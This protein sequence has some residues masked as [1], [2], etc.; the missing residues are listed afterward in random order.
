MRVITGQPS[1]T[2]SSPDAP[3]FEVLEGVSVHRVSLGGLKGRERFST[4]V[5]GYLRFL[6]GARQKAYRVIQ[7]E[8]PDIVLTFHNPPLVGWIGA[9]LAR[10]YGLPFVYVLYDIHPDV[11][12]RTGWKLPTPV[13]WAWERLNRRIYE[14]AAA[15]VVLGDAMRQVLARKGVP[16]EKVFV[17]PPWARPELAPLPRDCGPVLSL[18]KALGLGERDLL[19]LYAGNMGVMHPLDPLLD[20]AAALQGEP[21]HFLFLGDGVRRAQL[22][23]RVQREGLRQV[24]FLPYQPEERFAELVAAADACFVVLEPGLEQLAVPSRAFTFLSAGRPLIA[25]MAPEAEI[26]RLV[27]KAGCGWTVST[28]E[29]LRELL[30]Q[31]IET[32][33]EVEERGRRARE[34]Y[35]AEFRR[36][37]ALERYAQVLACACCPAAPKPVEVSAPPLTPDP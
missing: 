18:R 24:T 13:I 26:A 33:E 23:E 28:G 1:Y 5:L 10:R 34:I 19:L 22:V 20:A 2:R 27:Q 25:L 30:R 14:S 12:L 3:S 11:L 35:R 16:S 4:R 15:I 17:I 21:V 9:H 8:R 6:R 37:K 7:E 29:E 31:L 36:E 32:P